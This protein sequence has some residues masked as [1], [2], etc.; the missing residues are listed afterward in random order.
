MGKKKTAKPQE[1]RIDINKLISMQ[2]ELDTLRRENN[3]E[4]KKGWFERLTTKYYDFKDRHDVPRSVNRKTY[5]WLCLLGV[6]GAHHFYAGHWV[7]GL[8][9]LAF[10]WTGISIAM[11]VIDWMIAVPKKADENG[12]I[13]I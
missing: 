10:C 9:Y 11:S 7:K 4:T 3:I 1:E 13:L 5:C 12:K 2:E 8:L 6:V